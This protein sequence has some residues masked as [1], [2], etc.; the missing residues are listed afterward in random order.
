MSTDVNKT[1]AVNNITHKSM[2]SGLKDQ[3]RSCGIC[4][5]LEIEEEESQKEN[6]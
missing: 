6:K 4:Q 5:Q 3:S 1:V 2:S